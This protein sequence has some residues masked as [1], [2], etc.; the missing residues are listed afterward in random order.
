[1]SGSSRREMLENMANNAKQDYYRF[2]NDPD[3]FVDLSPEDLE[4]FNEAYQK[5][6][7]TKYFMTKSMGGGYGGIK[8]ILDMF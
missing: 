4:V 5:M 2:T 8:K 6:E 7:V 1:M 3:F